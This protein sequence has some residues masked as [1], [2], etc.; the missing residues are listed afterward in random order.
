M[1]DPPDAPAYGI[2]PM[3]NERRSFLRWAI[4][5]LSALF[6]AV[7]GIPAL[8]CLIDARNRPAARRGFR[9]VQGVKLTDLNDGKPRQGVIR[10]IRHDA[11]TLHPNDVIGRVWVVK[12]G[13]DLKAYT[14]I[15][16]HL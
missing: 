10:D 8:F 14:T 11:W 5:G 7:L 9:V 15:C 16:P 3:I 1:L 13:N 2:S 4:Y 6:S 12:R